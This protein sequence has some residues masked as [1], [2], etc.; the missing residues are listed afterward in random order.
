MTFGSLFTGIGGL[1]PLY[2]E[3]RWEVGPS[4]FRMAE[5]VSGRLDRFKAIGNAVVPDCAEWIG[6]RI[7][8]VN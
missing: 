5:R 4:V 1:E 2:G 3:G 6:R 8:E 7:Q